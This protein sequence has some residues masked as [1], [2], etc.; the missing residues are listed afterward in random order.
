MLV[1]RLGGSGDFE[2]DGT[3]LELD[4]RF[5]LTWIFLL[6]SYVEILWDPF[7]DHERKETESE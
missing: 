6:T 3:K 1:G 7:D 5:V 4:W 2:D